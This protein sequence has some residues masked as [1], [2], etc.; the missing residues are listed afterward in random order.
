MQDYKQDAAKEALKLIRPGTVVGF[1]AGSTMLHLIG[2]IREDRELAGSLTMVSSSF[3]TRQYLLR[4]GFV[5]QEMEWV[6]RADLYFDG[7]DQFDC[8]ATP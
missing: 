2:Y 5:V 8:R 7:C 4:Q 3:S 1:G 6:N